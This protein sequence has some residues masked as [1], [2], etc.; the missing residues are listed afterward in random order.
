MGPTVEGNRQEQIRKVMSEA[1]STL[2][3]EA[4]YVTNG[5]LPDYRY[6][7]AVVE[8]VR[9][10]FA[11]ESKSGVVLSRLKPAQLFNKSI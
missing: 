3:Q 10:I 4:G 6:M 11:D 8:R 5:S 2:A 7:I 9:A 1:P